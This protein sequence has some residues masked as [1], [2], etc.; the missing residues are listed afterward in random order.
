MTIVNIRFGDLK[1]EKQMELSAQFPNTMLGPEMSLAHI[2]MYE[3]K[4]LDVKI[5]EA[6]IERGFLKDRDIH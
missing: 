3:K 5:E 6:R 2:H 4:D 1:P